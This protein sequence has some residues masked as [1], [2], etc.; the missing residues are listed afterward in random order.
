MLTERINVEI[1][2]PRVREEI[3]EYE[4]NNRKYWISMVLLRVY[5]PS[6]NAISEFRTKQHF[7]FY[8][9]KEIIYR[10][11]E[12]KLNVPSWSFSKVFTHIR[13]ILY[14]CEEATIS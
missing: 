8:F 7:S 12:M 9:D 5:T 1:F 6:L 13:K 10:S 14:E 11:T 4:K 2:D 3:D